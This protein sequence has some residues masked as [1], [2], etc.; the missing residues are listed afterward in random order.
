MFKFMKPNVSRFVEKKDIYSLIKAL[1][2]DDDDVRLAAET[3]L[4]HLKYHFEEMIGPGVM[5]D[6]DV[7]RLI[8]L[9]RHQEKKIRENAILF[10]EEEKGDVSK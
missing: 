4:V 1:D 9:L 6:H 2:C 5:S 7:L 10:L 3:A 8:K